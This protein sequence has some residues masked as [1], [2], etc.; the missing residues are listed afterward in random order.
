MDSQDTPSTQRRRSSA[1]HEVGLEGNDIILDDKMKNEQRP[2]PSVK[3]R[4]N[5]SV[6]ETSACAIESTPS[7]PILQTSPPL[8]RTFS[9]SN[10]PF[11]PL[12]LLIALLALA[13]PTLNAPSKH[14]NLMP[15]MAEAGPVPPAAKDLSSTHLKTRDTST[16][17]CKRWAGQS[18]VVNGTIYYYGGRA[19]TS[20]SQQSD[21]WS[22]SPYFCHAPR[23]DVDTNVYR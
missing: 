7:T 17:V 18:A 11:A 15:A 10:I 13:F 23:H 14:S 8:T 9:I 1:F 6:V 20:A 19:T 16:D 4:S 12:A 22:K 2:R 3:F 5:V 21:E